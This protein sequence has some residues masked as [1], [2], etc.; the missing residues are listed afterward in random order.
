M[1]TKKQYADVNLYEKKLDAVMKRLKVDK[2][3]FDWS[4]NDCWV[5]FWLNGQLYRF[6]H[7]VKKALEHDI[8]ISYGSDAFAQLVLALEDLARITER[9][10]YELSTWVSGMKLLPESDQKEIP[11]FFTFMGFTE[12]PKTFEEVKKRYRSMSKTLHP[13]QEGGSEESFKKLLEAYG[14]AENYFGE[15]K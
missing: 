10:I 8:K 9:G 12:I 13:D 2:Y 4:R 14:E 6:D 15:N 3:E 5:E 7:G 11:F 1:A